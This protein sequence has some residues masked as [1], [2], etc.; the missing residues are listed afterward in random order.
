[1]GTG[2]IHLVMAVDS[3]Y[4]MTKGK[5]DYRIAAHIVFLHDLLRRII[6]CWIDILGKVCKVFVYKTAVVEYTA[7]FFNLWDVV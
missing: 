3:R 5:S 4:I 7:T 1:M 6:A 2:I